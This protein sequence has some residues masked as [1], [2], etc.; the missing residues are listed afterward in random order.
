MEH[1]SYLNLVS[2]LSIQYIA[3]KLVFIKEAIFAMPFNS[4]INHIKMDFD[5]TIHNMLYFSNT[6]GDWRVNAFL[7]EDT[8]VRVI[9]HCE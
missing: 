5:P 3:L 2:L 7:E 4:M 8:V 6:S 1:F 9:I